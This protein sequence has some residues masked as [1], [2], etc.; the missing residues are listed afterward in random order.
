[1][2]KKVICKECKNCLWLSYNGDGR[3]SIDCLI[4][5]GCD[6]M[7]HYEVTECEYFELPDYDTECWDENGY[8][9]TELL[10]VLRKQITMGSIYTDDY[11]NS[12]GIDPSFL[13]DFF[14]SYDYW[15]GENGKEESPENLIE[16]Y[17][18]YSD[19]ELTKDTLITE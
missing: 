10:P 8:F 14:E 13:Y 4:H 3:I 16:W 19:L 2:A 15:L 9:K 11:R 12:Y 6:G 7:L 1:M 5:E 17:Q 18:D